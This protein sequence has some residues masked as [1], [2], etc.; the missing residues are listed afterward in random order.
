MY[1]RIAVVVS[2]IAAS[3]VMNVSAFAQSDTGGQPDNTT[4]QG[5]GQGVGPGPGQGPASGQGPGGRFGRRQ[6]SGANGAGTGGGNPDFAARR[7]RMLEKFD[8]NHDGVL[9]DDE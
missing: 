8:T 4:P 9:S 2:S 1:R 7:Q 6:F 5:P 3:L